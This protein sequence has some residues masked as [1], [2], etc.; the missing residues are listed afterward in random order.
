MTAKQARIAVYGAG[1]MGTVL[2]A[3]LSQGGL[4]VDLITRNA[5]HVER[6]RKDGARIDCTADGTSRTICVNALLPTEMHGQYDV[7]FLMTKQRFNR[8]IVTDLLPFLAEDGAIVTTQNGLPEHGIAEIVGAERTYGAVTSFGANFMEAGRVELTSETSAMHIDVGGYCNDGAKLFL[9]REIL[10]YAKT[11]DRF[12][13]TTDDLPGSRWSK[14]AINAAFSGLSAM[15]GMTFGEV[16][17]KRK[18]RK[19]A[20]GVLRECVAVASAQGVKLAKMQGFDIAKF[21]AE[22]SPVKNVIAYM[23]LPFAMKK[24]KNLHSGMLKDIENGK[25]CEIDFIDGVVAEE[26]ARVGVP[27]PLCQRIV[28]IVHDIEN[29]LYETSYANTDF[30][31]DACTND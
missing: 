9:L 23:V 27:T 26:G 24:H 18:T 1:A 16:A 28:E 10:S 14:L 31:V 4:R 22:K 2:G 30:F 21:L 11:N 6:L 7:I 20:L 3:L 12:V 25:R 29:G 5:A 13:R 15:T 17:K 19:I 8:E